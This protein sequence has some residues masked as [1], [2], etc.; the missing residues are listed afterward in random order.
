MQYTISNVEALWPRINR[1][2]RFDKVERK[3]V[4]C[5]ARE[6]LAAYEMSFRM[7]SSQAKALHTAM[8]EAYNTVRKSQPAWPETFVNPFKKEEDTGCWIGKAKLKGAYNGE[9]T[10]KPKQYDLTGVVHGDDFLLT[11]GSKVN[12][13][14][15]MVP[16]SMKD[17]GVSLR[18]RAV[19]VVEYKPMESDNPFGTTAPTPRAAN[20]N[21]FGDNGPAVKPMDAF[22]LP[23]VQA[24]PAKMQPVDDF[25]DEIPF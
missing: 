1:T 25:G 9:L 13:A 7:T 22:G 10:Q 11:T 19:Q 21:P 17:N 18:L 2:Y 14:V 6:E 15:T 8:V 4:P 5:D 12:V 16:Y 23:P 3:S 24:K 20:D